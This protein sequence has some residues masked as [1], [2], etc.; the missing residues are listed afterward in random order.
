M[1]PLHSATLAPPDF[2][3]A[4]FFV[5]EDSQFHGPIRK[6]EAQAWQVRIASPNLRFDGR[7]FALAAFRSYS[8][9]GTL[10][11]DFIKRAPVAF[12]GR[13]LAAQRLPA[14]NHHVHVFRV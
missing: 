2:H 1:I 13:F 5:L 10:R 11:S 4:A 8:R 3:P 6:R 7:N 14:L 9:L 12:E